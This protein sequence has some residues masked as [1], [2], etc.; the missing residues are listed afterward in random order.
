MAMAQALE[1]RVLT[2]MEDRRPIEGDIKF[3][4]TQR[5]VRVMFGGI[6][7][8]DS[9]AVMLMIE[10][11][12]LAVY[13]FPMKD[14]RTEVLVPTEYTSDKPGKGKATFYSV[15]VGDRVA[16]KAAWRF[17]EPERAEFKDYIGFF[18]DKM[19]AWFE[20]DD[21]VF[22]HPR[23][24]YHRVD[25]LNS[26]REVKIVIGG[27]VVAET[28]RPRVLLETGLPPRYYIPKLDVRLDLLTSSVTHTRCP[29][30]GVASYWNVTI[31]GK[32]YKDIVWGYPAPIPECPKIENLLCFYDEKVDAVYVDGERQ[33]RPVTPFS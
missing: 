17:L 20:E 9:N 32:E 10:K 19:D 2:G 4:P 7:I 25:V 23:D 31:N 33:Q 27:E 11:R 14:V 1:D 30:K 3:E 29:Y 26:S 18:W 28:K 16:E 13:Y 5:R 12:R 6:T 22:V 21:E 24:P 8:A 15:K